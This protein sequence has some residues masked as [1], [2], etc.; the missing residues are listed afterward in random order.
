MDVNEIEQPTFVCDAHLSHIQRQ[1]LASYEI[2]RDVPFSLSQ[3]GL[4][5]AESPIIPMKTLGAAK[6]ADDLICIRYE[7]YLDKDIDELRQ[8]WGIEPYTGYKGAR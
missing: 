8:K 3:N 2:R 7:D 4:G 6:C 5:A 1:R